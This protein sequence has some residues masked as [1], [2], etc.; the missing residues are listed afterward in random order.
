MVLRTALLTSATML[1]CASTAAADA[2]ERVANG[3]FETGTSLTAPPWTF[4]SANPCSS[5]CGL[6]AASGSRY[7]TNWDFDFD[8]GPPQT[9]DHPIGAWEQSLVVPEAPAKLSFQVR[10]VLA[11]GAPDVGMRLTVTLDGTELADIFDVFETSFEHVTVPI[12]ATQIKMPAQLLKFETFCTNQS[13]LTADCDRLD[14]DDVSVVTGPPPEAP[15]I[16]GTAPA[17]P[18]DQTGPKVY[19]TVGAGAP[20]AVRI[21][22]N[23]TCA[24]AA[25]ATGSVAEFTGAGIAVSVPDGSTTALSA[26]AANLAGDST[27]SNS[28][29]YVE[30]GGGGAPVG[31]APGGGTSGGGPPGGSPLGSPAD[32]LSGLKSKF[33]VAASGA[34]LLG[35]ATNPPTSSTTQTLT[36]S[37]AGSSARRKKLVIGRGRTTVTGGTTRRVTLKLNRK[38]KRLLHKKRRL[39]AQLTIVAR[40][41]TG[42]SETVTKAVRLTVKRPRR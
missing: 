6:P 25:D 22:A 5:F 20:T 1:A 19:G 21:Y 28:V 35:K 11:E 42:L 37:V 27:C 16:A 3:G 8:S 31:G 23:A 40:G 9:L 30:L 33:L 7:A 26:S 29:T 4:T 38:G 2:T 14:V 15:A 18:A 41:P 36:A 17:S 13:A 32:G 10:R 34:L 39:R 24:G 12:P